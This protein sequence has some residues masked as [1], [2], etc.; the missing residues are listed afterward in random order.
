MCYLKAGVGGEQVMDSKIAKKI[1]TKTMFVQSL[2]GQN[3]TSVVNIDWY[4]YQFFI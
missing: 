3:T 4:F 2:P 1:N